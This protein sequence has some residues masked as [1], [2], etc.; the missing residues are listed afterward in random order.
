MNGLPERLRARLLDVASGAER[1]AA[2]E[3]VADR[4]AFILGPRSALGDMF[5]PAVAASLKRPVAVVDDLVTDATIH[6]LPRWSA[7]QF[8]ERVRDYPNAV[9]FD[10]SVSRF[11]STLF[12]ALCREARVE[13]RDMVAALGEFNLHTVYDSA[14][15]MRSETLAALDRFLALADRFEDDHSR[16]TLYAALLLRVTYDRLPLRDSVIGGEDEYFSQFART[17]T[18]RMREGEAFCDAGAHI[19]LVT[20][21]F[22]AATNWNFRSIHAFEPDRVTFKSLQKMCLLPLGNFHVRNRA[23]S[24][25]RETLSFAETGTVASHISKIGTQTCQTVL[26]DD[27]LESLSFLKMDIEGFEAKALRGARRLIGKFRP[28]IAVTA[29]HHPL[30]L[31]EIVE[32][33][34]DIHPGYEL[35]LRHHFN[36]YYDMVL[37]ACEKGGW[38]GGS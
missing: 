7:Y 21:K 17:K 27:E 10:F 14:P 34:E 3:P 24:D 37:Y 9:A 29:Y 12:E 6:G 16:A 1:V 35:R 32:T 31:L 36:F 18:F 30:D 19:G 13:R 22:L 2:L 23:L 11:A 33:L 26:L 28:R 8:A 20:A 25:V 5:G 15:V 4:P 38:D